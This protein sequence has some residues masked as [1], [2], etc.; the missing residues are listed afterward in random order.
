MPETDRDVLWGPAARLAAERDPCSF[1][2]DGASGGARKRNGPQKPAE[3]RSRERV[4][5]AFAFFD[6]KDDR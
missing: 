5:R 2:P 4:R 1:V 3:Q 6:E